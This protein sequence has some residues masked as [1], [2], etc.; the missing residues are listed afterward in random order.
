MLC[1]ERSGFLFAHDCDRIAS[2]S[3]I[4]CQKQICHMHTRTTERGALCIS[5]HKKAGKAEAASPSREGRR[6]E[7]DPFG[8]GD[9]YYDNYN[10]YDSDDYAAFDRDAAP[11]ADEREFESDFDGS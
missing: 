3:C 4:E 8:Y 7:G 6:Y 9:M 11:E 10:Y 5:C 2:S 1:K